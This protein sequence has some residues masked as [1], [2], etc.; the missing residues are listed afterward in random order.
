MILFLSPQELKPSCG[1]EKAYTRNSYLQT[2]WHVSA[3]I[4]GKLCSICVWRVKDFSEE[5][6][7]EQGWK[8]RWDF[9]RKSESRRFEVAR[10]KTE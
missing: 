9:N 5:I 10:D 7:I 1:G 4:S 8:D 3:Q 6:I 2:R